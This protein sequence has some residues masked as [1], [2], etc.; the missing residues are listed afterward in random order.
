MG[1]SFVGPF[2]IISLIG[3]NAVKVKITEEFFRKYPVLP[4]SLVKPYHQTG[5]DKLPSRNK[6]HTP[7]KIMEVEDP[8]GPVKKMIKARMIR[9]NGKDHRQ[10]LV[11]L[12]NQTPY[13]EKWL[14]EDAIPDGKPHLRRFRGSRRA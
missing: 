2:N 4:V 13:K 10:Y 14:E 7:Q 8:P 12:K 11:R 3:E 1:D 5:E 9:L 6:G